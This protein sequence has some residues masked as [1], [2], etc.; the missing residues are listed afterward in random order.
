VSIEKDEDTIVGWS[1]VRQA[2]VLQRVGC[3]FRRGG[4]ERIGSG[5]RGIVYLGDGHLEKER[6]IA[7]HFQRQAQGLE[8]RASVEIVCC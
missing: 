3:G 8:K 5:C 2:Q 1:Y 7:S 6:T 4:Y